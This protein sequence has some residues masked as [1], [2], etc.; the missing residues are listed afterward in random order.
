[1]HARARIF[2]V[3]NYTAKFKSANIF[4][5]AA[6]D[7]TAKFKDCQYFRLYGIYGLVSALENHYKLVLSNTSCN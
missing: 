1:M 6:Q 4:I 3:R 5:S 2:Y 7:Q